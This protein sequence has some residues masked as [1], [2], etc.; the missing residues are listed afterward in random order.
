VSPQ[1]GRGLQWAVVTNDILILLPMTFLF[2]AYTGE[3]AWKAIGD[4]LE[5]LCRVG[6]IMIEKLGAGSKRQISKN[7]P[8]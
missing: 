6:S 5:K 4:R 3:R 1:E 8:S 7:I 2:K